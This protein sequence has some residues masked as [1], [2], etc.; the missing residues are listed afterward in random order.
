MTAARL[1]G[2][3]DELA[4]VDA[5][6]ERI[7]REG[8]ALLV[9]G[10]PGIGKS[11]LLGAAGATARERGLVVLSAIGVQSEADLPFAGLHQLL[12]PIV[13]RVERLRT[14]QRAAIS[15]AFGMIDGRVPDLFV[16]A[17]AALNLLAEAADRAPLLLLVEDAH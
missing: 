11:E 14:P 9:R 4:I 13:E 7:P 3:A 12:L 2:R 5:L 17:L 6:V 8:G 15:A 10:G 1:F 16:V